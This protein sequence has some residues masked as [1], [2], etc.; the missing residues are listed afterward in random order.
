VSK[1]PSHA[2]QTKVDS[3]MVKKRNTLSDTLKFVDIST[4][5]LY[6]IYVSILLFQH[7][8]TKLF[9]YPPYTSNSKAIQ[10][11]A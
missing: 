7:T 11:L 2:I 8:K 5:D 4:M 1:I 6:I 10:L 3:K 9:N